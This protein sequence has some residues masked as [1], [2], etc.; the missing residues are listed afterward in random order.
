M[1][2]VVAAEAERARAPPEAALVRRDTYAGAESMAGSK[3]SGAPSERSG[4][5]PTQ[6][7]TPPL[8]H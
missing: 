5:D 8:L 6:P 4:V 1:T 2:V 3:R 7:A